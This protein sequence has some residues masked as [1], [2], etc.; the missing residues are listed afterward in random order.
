MH[1]WGEYTVGISG[2]KA[3]VPFL[4]AGGAIDYA[5]RERT[6]EWRHEIE[7]RQSRLA[8]YCP[9]CAN[10]DNP[11]VETLMRRNELALLR[12]D[13]AVFL[14]DGSFTVGTPVE[15]ALR[16]ARRHPSTVCIVH[17]AGSPGAFVKHWQSQGVEVRLRMEDL[18][19]WLDR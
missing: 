13:R 14:L 18:W 7:R 10:A 12:A 11:G 15:V 17:T 1:D 4:Y 2:I 5:D 19:G 8:V 6:H 16:V 9:L 3:G